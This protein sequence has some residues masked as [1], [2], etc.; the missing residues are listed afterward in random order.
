MLTYSH[1]RGSFVAVLVAFLLVCLGLA[2]CGGSAG[3]SQGGV[4][5]ASAASTTGRDQQATSGP[6]IPARGR[7]LSNPAF[8]QTLTKFVVCLQKHGVAVPTPST[9]GSGPVLNIKGIDTSSAKF[10]AAWA[11]CRG[12]VDLGSAFNKPEVD[13]KR[14]DIGA[15]RGAG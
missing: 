8:R 4:V 5:S 3:G 13:S 11:R 1:P 14:P 6:P 15:L 12:S 7:R 9:S 10:K 2:A